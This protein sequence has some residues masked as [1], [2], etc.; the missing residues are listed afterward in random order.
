MCLT[1]TKSPH[2]SLPCFQCIF[3]LPTRKKSRHIRI[4]ADGDDGRMQMHVQ[5]ASQL[6]PNFLFISQSQLESRRKISS[7]REEHVALIFFSCLRLVPSLL[8]WIALQAQKKKRRR[9]C[10]P[11]QLF[12]DRVFLAEKICI[13]SR[14]FLP[15]FLVMTGFVVVSGLSCSLMRACD[16]NDVGWL[17]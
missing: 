13:L 15:L 6:L 2:I 14:I 12:I 16:C 4:F 9:K 5:C 17:H 1:Q 11:P 3:Y 7:Q 10:F 8:F